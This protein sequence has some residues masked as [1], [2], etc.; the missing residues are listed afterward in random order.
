MNDRYL[1]LLCLLFFHTT[2]VYLDDGS[3]I[4]RIIQAICL[5]GVIIL[6][7]MKRQLKLKPQYKMINGFVVVYCIAML[8]ISYFS[9]EINIDKLNQLG[10]GYVQDD[11]KLSSYTLGIMI[12]VSVYVA[13]SLVE[14]LCSI[15]KTIILF[16]VFY[17]TFLFYLIISDLQFLIV[18]ETTG[19][20]GY[21]VGNKFSLSY[22]HILCYILYK[23]TETLECKKR[24][25]FNKF[26]IFLTFAI[27]LLTGCT[28]ALIGM[29]AI[30]LALHLHNSEL[31]KLLYNGYTYIAILFSGVIFMFSYSYVLDIPVI[32]YIIVDVLHED[33]TLTGRTGIYDLMLLILPARPIWGFGVGNSHWVLAYLFGIANAQNG[34]VNLYIEEGLVG[35]VLYLLIFAS[36]FRYS[37]KHIPHN[38]TFPLLCYIATFFF[39]GLVE[40][41][42]DNKLLIIMSFLLAYSSSNFNSKKYGKSKYN[43][44]NI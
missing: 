28:T 29:F 36:I 27:S 39:M 14:Y 34:L 6:L 22:M 41:T 35:V 7:L 1:K 30:V 23:I 21:L 12:S 15:N 16:R 10:I 26:L 2:F 5:G 25:I 3:G 40:I 33:L 8:F 38:F 9:K 11:L 42:I 20:E 24:K 18:G 43:C 4:G 13:F 37:K 31:Y 19:N 32:Q 17:K 44:S